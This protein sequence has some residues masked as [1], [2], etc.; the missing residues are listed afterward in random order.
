[1]YIILINR[2]GYGEEMI[3]KVVKFIC[4]K[5]QDRIHRLVVA[6]K[7]YMEEYEDEEK[8]VRLRM[9]PWYHGVL[10]DRQTAKIMQHY[11]HPN[12]T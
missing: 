3:R 6:R 1:M 12:P 5:A 4:T 11:K 7:F 2:F 9:V 8:V 10:S